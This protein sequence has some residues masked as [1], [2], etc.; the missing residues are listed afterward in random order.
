[1]LDYPENCQGILGRI[2]KAQGSGKV[3]SLGTC[4][5]DTS[6]AKADRGW[7]FKETHGGLEIPGLSLPHWPWSLP[8]ATTV[9][10]MPSTQEPASLWSEAIC[11]VD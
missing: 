4:L 10:G 11:G 1:M 9:F 7:L 5:W 2:W 6:T 3:H 8:D